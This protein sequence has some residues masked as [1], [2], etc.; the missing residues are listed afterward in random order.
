MKTLTSIKELEYFEKISPKC[1]EKYIPIYTSK[2]VKELQKGFTFNYASQYRQSI[3]AHY[4][5]MS[6]GNDVKL[7]IENSFDRSRSLRISFQYNRFVFGFNSQIHLGESAKAI[8]EHYDQIADL[9]SSSAKVVDAL[10]RIKFSKDEQLDILKIMLKYKN[11]SLKRLH[12][13]EQYLDTNLTAIEYI[14]RIIDLYENGG[15]Q[16]KDV[17]MTKGLIG[18][19]IRETKGSKNTFSKVCLSKNIYDYIKEQYIEFYL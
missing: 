8:S 5:I 15:L 17:K 14:D 9:Y 12:N 3:N 16:V 7:F 4:V 2:L 6:K 11:I 18:G 13:I 10:T 19:K 1:S